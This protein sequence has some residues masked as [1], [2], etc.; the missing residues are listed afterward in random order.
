MASKKF[1][2]EQV[3]SMLDD[4]DCDELDGDNSSDESGDESP[5]VSGDETGNDSDDSQTLYDLGTGSSASGAGQWQPSSG[6]TPSLPTFT[7]QHKL[8]IDS[9]NYEAVDYFKLFFDDDL[10]NHIVIETNRYAEQQ[11]QLNPAAVKPHSRMHNWIPT[12]SEEIQKFFGLTFLMGI[13][14]KPKI[15]MYWS[16][17]PLY[18]TPIFAEIMPR[19]R[20]QLLLRFL[21]FADNSTSPDPTNPDRDRLYKIRSII[22]HLFEKFQTVYDV[23][24]KVSVDESLLLWKGRLLFRQ[25]LPLK[26]S[27][28]GIKLYK[29]CESTTG[30]TYRFQVYVGKDTSF[31]LPV[32][33]PAPAVT[34]SATE[35]IVWFL[36]LP[37][38]NK[39]HHLYCDNFYTSVSLFENLLQNQTAAC[40]TVR[41]NRKDMPKAL[42][43]KKQ[44]SGETSFM[45]KDG[46]LAVKF[47]D[48][49]DIYMLTTIH[50]DSCETVSVRRR[51]TP[52]LNKPTCVLE[53][54]KFMGGVDLSDQ[55]LESYDASRKSMIWYKKLSI[56]LLQHAMNNAFIL[57]R[58]ST[59]SS[60][61]TSKHDRLLNFMHD[62][63]G[64]LLFG[65]NDSHVDEDKSECVVRLT[66]RHFPEK[67]TATVCK[68]KPTK[69]CRVCYKK[70][71]RAESR[72][73]CTKCPSKPALCIDDCFAEY[74]TKIKY[75]K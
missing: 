59:S 55:L 1:T 17:D 26:R 58:Q 69:R 45:K 70:G 16:K 20:Y 44:T 68:D 56:Y 41:C 72:F 7:G 64:D 15:A 22:D 24:Q 12:T 32:G 49:K 5:S 60:T 53:Y 63:I 42:V 65:P 47:T 3:I 4:S 43:S 35:K 21:H 71:K 75:W 34:L 62:V 28:Y 48:R 31:E 61:V 2:K 19:N 37:L 74:H 50:D 39:G 29:L 66:G 57:Y 67:I 46:L 51:A 9:T 40:G 30:Y 52:T 27:R 73:F 8:L 11:L 13:I 38:L 18:T 23:S 54:N 14:K 25:Y 6:H 33:V 10:V 36:M